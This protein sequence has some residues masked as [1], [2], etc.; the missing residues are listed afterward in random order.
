[1]A[2]KTSLLRAE[3]IEKSINVE[4]LLHAIISQHY[5]GQV[6]INFVSE[7]LYDEYC[8]FALK[9]RVVL[10]IC[11]ELK[12][13]VENQ[14]NRLNSIRNYFAHVGQPMIE[15]PNSKGASRVPDP[16]DFANSV[17]FEGLHKE[18]NNI[19]GPLVKA[20]VNAYQEKGGVFVS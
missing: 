9:R 13:S 10:K 18:F 17:D 4:W 5:F 7:L 1:M 11:P 3:V 15:G 12:G 14:L 20:L 8:S 19:E 16:R 2:N 6:R